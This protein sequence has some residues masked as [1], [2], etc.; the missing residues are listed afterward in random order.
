LHGTW[1][2]MGKGSTMGK[3]PLIF[4]GSVFTSEDEHSDSFSP[5]AFLRHESSYPSEGD[6]QLVLLPQ[7]WMDCAM[8]GAMCLWNVHKMKFEF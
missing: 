3:W 7:L 6:R 1:A 5:S 4:L 8:P 2:C